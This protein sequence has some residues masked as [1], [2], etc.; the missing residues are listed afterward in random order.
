MPHGEIGDE[1]LGKAPT[2]SDVASASS[3][4]HFSSKQV[5]LTLPRRHYSQ[6]L[7]S[8]WWVCVV[9]AQYCK[10]K[11]KWWQKQEAKISVTPLLKKTLRAWLLPAEPYEWATAETWVH[12]SWLNLQAPPQNPVLE[13]FFI[14]TYKAPIHRG[15][16]IWSLLPIAS[17]HAAS[18]R[19]SLVCNEHE[20]LS[21]W[22]SIDCT[23]HAS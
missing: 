16:V 7:P 15:K 22:E 1:P 18:L 4:C 19:C 10:V 11:E 8:L 14:L 17:L 20:L 2:G 12:T 9:T 3:R 5:Q 13:P 23:A 6:L 21:N